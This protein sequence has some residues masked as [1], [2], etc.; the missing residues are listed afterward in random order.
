MRVILEW[1]HADASA[2]QSHVATFQSKKKDVGELVAC[3]LSYA[4]DRHGDL[5][6]P[7]VWHRVSVDNEGQGD[8]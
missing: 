5:F 4:A 3:C 7:W 1:K 2:D 8:E 6:M